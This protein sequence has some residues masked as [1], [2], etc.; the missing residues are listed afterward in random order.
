MIE[1][2]ISIRF[3]ILKVSTMNI[4]VFWN[5]MQCSVGDIC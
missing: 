3:E 1:T 2:V 4:T 5:V